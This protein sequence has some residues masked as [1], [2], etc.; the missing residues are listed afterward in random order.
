MP[1]KK[2]LGRGLDALFINNTS[3]KGAVVELSIDEINPNRGQPRQNFED[4]ALAELADSIKMHG[5]IQPLAVRGLIDGSYEIIAGERRY[6]AARMAGLRKLPV[7]ILS[8][9]KKEAMELTLIENLQREDLNAIEEARGYSQLIEE[10]SLKQEDVANRVSK[11]RSAITNSLRLLAL[12][13]TVVE[14][15]AENKLSAGHGRALLTLPTDLTEKVAAEVIEKNMSVRALEVY[16]KLLCAE[17]KTKKVSVKK[18]IYREVEISLS[19]ALGRKIEVR[20]KGKTGVIS[21]EFL[22]DDELMNFANKLS[23]GKNK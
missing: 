11:S 19:E 23:E 17:K 4:E 7:V 10:F 5:I 20:R 13:D 3:E 15:I 6:R 14:L 9:D 8:V 16:C 12:P 22:S 1:K 21:I 18:T 2:G